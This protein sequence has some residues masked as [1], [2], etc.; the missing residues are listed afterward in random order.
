MAA[1]RPADVPVRARAAVPA[2]DVSRGT[3]EH[4]FQLEGAAVRARDA[5]LGF[6][7]DGG[8]DVVFF[9]AVGAA[10]I[11]EGHGLNSCHFLSLYFSTFSSKEQS[12]IA[13]H[14]RLQ[15]LRHPV[16]V[17]AAADKIR[18]RSRFF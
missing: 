9:I 7:R 14:M 17:I 3:L 15:P 13:E 2:F 12:S 4:G 8:G 6:L 1:P 18:R 5:L 11:V 10:Q 16:L